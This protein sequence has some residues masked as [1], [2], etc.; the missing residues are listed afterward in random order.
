MSTISRFYQGL[1]FNYENKRYGL[2]AESTA[3]V[4]A[5]VIAQV[6]K[7][8]TFRGCH[9]RVKIKK[10]LSKREGVFRVGTA[11]LMPSLFFLP[12]TTKI[13]SREIFLTDGQTL[14]I[15]LGTCAE[16]GLGS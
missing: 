9:G 3:T 1:S 2:V 16:V 6:A 10:V 8:L 15:G 4:T 5:T 14:E 7:R 11:A 12:E 13:L